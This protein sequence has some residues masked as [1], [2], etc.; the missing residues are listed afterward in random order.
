MWKTLPIT[1]AMFLLF[2]S[3]T[4]STVSPAQ[5]S[6]ASD[7]EL[8]QRMNQLE[9]ETQAL[10]SEVK[11]LRQNV[12]RLP[13]V[14]LNVSSNSVILASST[15]DSAAPT[16]PAPWAV[17][18]SP[19]PQPTS[20][21]SVQSVASNN[22]VEPSPVTPLPPVTQTATTNVEKQPDAAP[23]PTSAPQEDYYT[24]DEIKGEMKKLVWKKG[25]FTIT[26]YGYLWGTTVYE[27]E[28]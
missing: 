26:P 12:V 24:L 2:I 15:A 27:T 28:R 4:L 13:N 6:S 18:V 9:A 8:I 14:E 1:L 3:M 23:V 19:A 25:D 21:P 7:E 22:A 16:P 5:Q 10:R 20:V 11:T 17:P